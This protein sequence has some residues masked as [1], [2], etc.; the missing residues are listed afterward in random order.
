MITTI[1]SIGNS[2]GVRIPKPLLSESGLGN[3]V[4]LQVKKGEIK[5]VPAPVK[6]TPAEDTLVLSEK[7]LNADWNRPEED[8][9]WAS[10]QQEM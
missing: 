8:T 10:L 1:I 2:R 4:E 5:I 7:T 3:E 9:A 6:S